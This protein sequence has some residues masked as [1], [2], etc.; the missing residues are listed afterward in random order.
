MRVTGAKHRHSINAC[1]CG[2][3]HQPNKL[4]KTQTKMT[5]NSLSVDLPFR[6]EDTRDEQHKNIEQFRFSIHK[7]LPRICTVAYVASGLQQA[8]QDTP[9]HWY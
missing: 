6:R 7:L 2:E 1:D 8:V 9:H 4:R 3:A 5:H